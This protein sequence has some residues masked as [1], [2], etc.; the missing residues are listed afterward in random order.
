MLVLTENFIT[1]S[2]LRGRH[3][4]VRGGGGR[5]VR[6]QKGPLPSL[7]N[8]PPF[9]LPPYPLPLSTP[10][11]QATPY[12]WNPISYMLGLPIFSSLTMYEIHLKHSQ[13]RNKTLP[14]SNLQF[15]LTAS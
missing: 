3:K 2:S 1:L 9:S 10:V 12:L 6:K 13:G 15:S 7:P 8:L 14:L 11:T 5:K 4:K